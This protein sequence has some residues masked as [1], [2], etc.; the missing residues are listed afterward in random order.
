MENINNLYFTN[1]RRTFILS[2]TAFINQDYRK[3]IRKDKN[4]L[5]KGKLNSRLEEMLANE[6]KI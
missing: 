6:Q 4:T 3:R 2:D 5:S 1:I